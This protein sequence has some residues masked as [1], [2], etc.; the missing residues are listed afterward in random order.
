MT[1]S[2]GGDMSDMVV[3]KSDGGVG[4]VRNCLWPVV[5]GTYGGDDKKEDEL[6][7]EFEES[8]IPPQQR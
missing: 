1:V 5:I 8:I 3:E 6:F 7:Q 2:H 4:I